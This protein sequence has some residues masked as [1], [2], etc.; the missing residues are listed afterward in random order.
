MMPLRMHSVRTCLLEYI[1]AIY[2]LYLGTAKR[3]P[4]DDEPHDELKDEEPHDPEGEAKASSSTEEAQ[5]A[6]FVENISNLSI[7]SKH[8]AVIAGIGAR[9]FRVYIINYMSQ[10]LHLSS[11]GKKGD[12]D[13][14][15]WQIPGATPEGGC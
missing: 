10:I 11:P 1:W 12:G 6:L 14:G 13:S 3:S 9:G 8:A 15:G 5:A 2:S 7:S 4:K